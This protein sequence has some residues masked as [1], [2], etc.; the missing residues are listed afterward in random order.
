MNR[1]LT[2]AAPIALACAAMGACD[3]SGSV[4]SAAEKGGADSGGDAVATLGAD[5]TF[6]VTSHGATVVSSLPGKPLLTRAS[7]PSAPDAWHDPTL[8]HADLAWTAVDASAVTLASSTDASGVQ[9]FHLTVA[10]QPSD[11]ALLS[12][13]LA[14]D[15]GFY[16]GLGEH[17]DH[18]SARGRVSPMFLTISS[19]F[20]S[21]TNE[22]HVPVPLLVSSRG[23]GLFVASREAGAFDVAATDAHTVRVTFEGRP[24]A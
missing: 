20:E 3:Q 23:W 12:L 1:S 19:A 17:F 2:L 10:K 6:A 21:G 13:T 7:D 5:G 14:A 15:D 22:A 4:L 24:P 9:A 11:T 18:V 8:P 16:T